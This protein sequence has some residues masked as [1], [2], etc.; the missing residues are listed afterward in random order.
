VLTTRG[1]VHYVVTEHGIAYLHGKSMR[2]RAMALINVAHPDFRQELLHA[3]K[4]RRLVY[5]H[6]IVPPRR[7]VYPE[8]LETRVKLGDGTDVLLRPVKHTDDEQMKELFYS[9]SEHTLYL[10]FHRV[11]KEMPHRKRQ[12]FVNIDYFQ[13]MAIVAVVDVDGREEFVGS[14][15]Y[16]MDEGTKSAEVAFAVRD[17]W[18]GRGLGHLLFTSLA[19]IAMD[20]NIHSFTADVLAENQAMLRV[21]R[22]GGFAMKTD[23]EE[24]VIHVEIDLATMESEAAGE[25]EEG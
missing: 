4:S 1:D 20:R 6:Q 22:G 10:R 21:F 3:A 5:A 7:A 12:M 8:E 18:Q 11:L 14:S 15:R 16:M 17:D 19:R 24:G 25:S 9:F 13:E 23:R 2:H